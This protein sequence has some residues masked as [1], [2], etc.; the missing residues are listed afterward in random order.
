MMKKR[1]QPLYGALL[2]L[3]ISLI[4]SACHKSANPGMAYIPK[5]ANV[6]LSFNVKQ[7]HDKLK[8]GNF[9][10]DS[11]MNELKTQDSSFALLPYLN[12]KVPVLT[13]FKYKSSMMTGKDILIGVVG[14]ISDRSGF[15]KELVAIKPGKSIVKKDDYSYLLL[16]DNAVYVWND[17]IITFYAGKD[18]AVQIP[19]LFHIK[20]DS[21]LADDKTA[22]KIL[23]GTGDVSIY[24]SS[25]DGMTGIPMLSMTKISDLIKG[26][27]WGATLNFEKGEI[28]MNGDCYYNK[29]VEDLI[30]KNPS[31]NINK[32]VLAHFPG[33]PLGLF[34]V[35]LNLKQIF[36]FLDYAG[37]T[38]MI[39]GYMKNLGITLDDVAKAFSGE[40][41]LAMQSATGSSM[42]PSTPKILTVV[43]IGDK[44]SFDKVMGAMAKMGA[45]EQINGQWV[46]KGMKAEDSWSFHSDDKSIVFSTDKDIATAY[47]SGKGQMEYP[48]N[49]DFSGKTCVAYADINGILTQMASREKTSDSAS[50]NLA[51]QTFEDV[52]LSATNI[53]GNHS[54]M[55]M[56]LRL[57]DKNQNSLPLLISTMQQFKKLDEAKAAQRSAVT[58]SLIVPLPPDLEDS[59]N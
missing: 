42:A 48:K 49:V 44:S 27:Y 57:K 51:I 16:D 23:N 4:F 22:I 34:Q 35:S 2:I 32:A 21:S 52:D 38:S 7:M 1:I 6:V 9:N 47:V 33:K 31:E 15:E 3:F 41:A 12:L 46:P 39:E 59:A 25:R 28:V 50:L 55:D 58:D 54:S 11:L 8:D 53:K 5:D 26:N 40:I 20:K 56:T 30:K 17:K 18:I 36:S 13:F 10:L 37:V 24:S 43:P 14:Q 45:V 29:T 19:S